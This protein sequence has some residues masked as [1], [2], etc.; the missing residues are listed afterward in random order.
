MPSNMIAH[1]YSLRLFLPST[2]AKMTKS[3]A[4][5]IEAWEFQ[6]LKEA[7]SVLPSPKC[8]WLCIWPKL[9]G[10]GCRGYFVGPNSNERIANRMDAPARTCLPRQ[11]MFWGSKLDGRVP[12]HSQPLGGEDVLLKQSMPRRVKPGVLSARPPR[13]GRV[14]QAEYG[15][16]RY[17]GRAAL[18]FAAWEGAPTR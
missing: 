17:F 6:I 3:T 12:L 10:S 2:A 7:S 5:E 18:A 14:V 16:G 9:P 13:G 15:P 4:S 1:L 8:P 11:H